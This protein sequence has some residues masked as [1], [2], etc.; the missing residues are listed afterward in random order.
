MRVSLHC[1]VSLPA[2]P[3]SGK[4]ELARIDHP[5]CFFLRCISRNQ[6]QK[7]TVQACDGIEPRARIGARERL[8]VTIV[9]VLLTSVNAPNLDR[10]KNKAGKQSRPRHMLRH[11]SSVQEEANALH[12]RLSSRP[13]QPTSM[14]CCG[15][16]ST[17]Q[18][19]IF[20][21]PRSASVVFVCGLIGRPIRPARATIRTVICFKGLTSVVAITTVGTKRP[22]SYVA[23][24][25]GCCLLPRGC[26]R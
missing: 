3:S 25:A 20:L 15:M 13:R 17:V 22:T 23:S 2:V 26:A 9:V 8:L 14:P 10:N 1:L 19:F 18:L 11:R 6:K 24:R 21:P 7:I 5:S 4:L 16:H 12:P